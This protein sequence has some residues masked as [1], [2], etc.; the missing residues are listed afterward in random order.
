M[1][2]IGHLAMLANAI[3]PLGPDQRSLLW[4][5]VARVIEEGRDRQT[6][7]AALFAVSNQTMN[8]QAL[9][10]FAPLLAAAVAKAMS[11]ESTCIRKEASTAVHRLLGIVPQDM[12]QCSL[13]GT[14]TPLSMDVGWA[15][16]LLRLCLDP[17]PGVRVEALEAGRRAVLC[18]KGFKGM[19]MWVM[20]RLRDGSLFH[21]VERVLQGVDCHASN[22]RNPSFVNTKPDE[23][24]LHHYVGGSVVEDRM[25][26]TDESR[27]AGQERDQGAGSVAGRKDMTRRTGMDKEEQVSPT[28][29]R[30]KHAVGAWA[31]HVALAPADELLSRQHR[32]LFTQITKVLLSTTNN[33]VDKRPGVRLAGLEAWGL[34]VQHCLGSLDPG[35]VLKVAG[36]VL[37]P[38]RHLV[39]RERDP[40]V[41][42]TLLSLLRHCVGAFRSP[43]LGMLWQKHQGLGSLLCDMTGE[44]STADTRHATARIMAEMLPLPSHNTDQHHDFFP[45]LVKSELPL[46]AELAMVQSLLS[47]LMSALTPPSYALAVSSIGP[48][49]PCGEPPTSREIAPIPTDNPSPAPLLDELSTEGLVVRAW[50]G[51]IFWA[52]SD[53]IK[54]YRTD[55]QFGSISRNKDKDLRYQGLDGTRDGNPLAKVLEWLLY[56]PGQENA[57]IDGGSSANHIG[58]PSEKNVCAESAQGVR[59]T[60]VLTPWRSVLLCA[61]I[62]MVARENISGLGPSFEGLGTTGRVLQTRLHLDLDRHKTEEQPTNLGV[63]TLNPVHTLHCARCETVKAETV[64]ILGQEFRNKDEMLPHGQ[65]MWWWLLFGVLRTQ[66]TQINLP[67]AGCGVGKKEELV[68]GK[69]CQPCVHA[70]PSPLEATLLEVADLACPGGLKNVM[71][72]LLSSLLAKQVPSQQSRTSHRERIAGCEGERKEGSKGTFLLSRERRSITLVVLGQL[73][74]AAGTCL[75]TRWRYFQDKNR[76]SSNIRKGIKSLVDIENSLEESNWLPSMAVPAPDMIAETVNL[77]R[78]PL[79]IGLLMFDN[80]VSALLAERK[81]AEGSVATSGNAGGVDPYRDP[82]NLMI[83]EDARTFDGSRT[84]QGS[85]SEHP[86]CATIH[87]LLWVDTLYDAKAA[88]VWCDLAHCIVKWAPDSNNILHKLAKDC[89]ALATAT[90]QNC[91]RKSG[92]SPT[93]NQEP[94]LSMWAVGVAPTPCSQYTPGEREKAKVE[95]SMQL[96][97]PLQPPPYIGTIPLLASATR[98]LLQG[99]LEPSPGREPALPRIAKTGLAML[100]W[101]LLAPVS[102]SFAGMD[103]SD[104]VQHEDN[105]GMWATPLV[106]ELIGILDVVGESFGSKAF[107]GAG[108]IFRLGNDILGEVTRLLI[109]GLQ[110]SRHGF[111]TPE[112]T[113]M[114]PSLSWSCVPLRRRLRTLFMQLMS[115]LEGMPQICLSSPALLQTLSPLF[116]A[117]LAMPATR[118]SEHLQS[119]F[120]DTWKSTFGSLPGGGSWGE[121]FPPLLLKG[122]TQMAE[123]APVVLPMGLKLNVSTEEGSGAVFA[124]EKKQRPDGPSIGNGSTEKVSSQLLNAEGGGIPSV[125]TAWSNKGMKRSFAN[126]GHI[127]GENKSAKSSSSY[128]STVS[129]NH[130]RQGV[131]VDEGE[132]FMRIMGNGKGSG[133][134][135]VARGRKTKRA[136]IMTYTSLDGSQKLLGEEDSQLPDTDPE[137]LPVR[138]FGGTCDE[139]CEGNAETSAIFPPTTTRTSGS[140]VVRQE[141]G[142]Q[143]KK[144]T[145]SWSIKHGGDQVI[146]RE[147]SADAN[148]GC[149]PV[150]RVLGVD[151]T[152]EEFMRQ[153]IILPALRANLGDT[154]TI[155]AESVAQ[156]LEEKPSKLATTVCSPEG[157]GNGTFLVEEVKRLAQIFAA[158]HSS[159][160]ENRGHLSHLSSDELGEVKNLLNRMSDHVWNIMLE[161]SR[162]QC[163]AQLGGSRARDCTADDPTTTEDHK[164]ENREPPEFM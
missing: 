104:C 56:R 140:T 152:R 98:L 80:D 116:E 123:H 23:E 100:S 61:L 129:R 15:P 99:S 2:Q 103:A 154:S 105:G 145:E 137:S 151:H 120:L 43:S 153:A 38:F 119:A 64:E 52:M 33:F 84:D 117:V 141:Q 67:N 30:I 79:K 51:L 62:R 96:C 71:A 74:R 18:L 24:N 75:L 125:Q 148:E 88:G 34:F 101:I 87:D 127:S 26:I 42:T 59:L 91:G 54:T 6:T 135:V 57:C 106:N 81:L 95:N 35:K 124:T 49:V 66:C 58:T 121:A 156:H 17:A 48:A 142:Q 112:V 12:M 102:Q 68:P 133:Q 158:N 108:T 36:V 40:V 76:G 63:I 27:E 13:G 130:Y 22:T 70:T 89:S 82:T 85:H 72:A 10:P 136:A 55:D 31:V 162:G 128:L 92:P 134:G 14:I 47:S 155:V 53:F 159:G 144:A 163:D 65:P 107:R 118:D 131:G 60:L 93:D 143:K 138:P 11:H 37:T 146:T 157:G 97:G 28:T 16:A 32:K 115:A 160:A 39:H 164:E 8:S 149:N 1:Y 139:K 122:L 5:T 132:S 73:W 25:Q 19:G 45:S 110:S 94:K 9:A 86:I 126:V 4:N 3:P 41:R 90:P 78:E 29:T 83:K 21:D 50:C 161:R 20:G 150:D 69:Q 77:V 7:V 44:R 46:E 147:V 109:L 111:C 113:V 114:Y